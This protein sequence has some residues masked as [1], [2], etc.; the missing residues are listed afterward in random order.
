MSATLT[1]TENLLEAPTLKAAVLYDEYSS[2]CRAKAFFDELMS[3]FDGAVPMSLVLWRMDLMQL[4]GAAHAALKDFGCADVVLLALRDEGS[5][6]EAVLDW[7]ESWARRR[8]DEE[9]ALLVLWDCREPAIDNGRGPAAVLR[10]LQELARRY[11]LS[12][13]CE[14]GSEPS[15][16][17]QSFV[18]GLRLREQASTP[19]LV[20]IMANADVADHRHWGLND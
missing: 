19:T 9:S 18:E 17:S 20:Q 11:G 15:W 12:F 4:P 5:V 16:E 2:G 6:P 8:A 14:W 3:R 7:V 10:R 1:D 13:F